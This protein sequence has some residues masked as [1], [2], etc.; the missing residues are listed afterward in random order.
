MNIPL[1]SLRSFIAVAE[2]GSMTAATQHIHISH[3]AV[4]QAIKTLEQQLGVTLFDRVGRQV[5]LNQV[6]KQYYHR[7]APALAEIDA[8]S[9]EAHNSQASSPPITLNMVNSLALHWWIPR[10]AKIQQALPELDIRLSTIVGK[11]DLAKHNVDV[12]LIHGNA[13]DWREYKCEQLADDE[14]VLVCSPLLLKDATAQTQNWQNLLTELPA[15]F[16]ANPRRESD[17]HIWCHANN[18]K[19]PPQ[20]KNLTF[21]T[22]VQATQAAIRQL[23]I[24]VSHRLFVKDDVNLGLLTEIGPVTINPTNQFNIISK[25]NINKSSEKLISWIKNE[26]VLNLN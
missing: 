1:K 9:Q 2:T 3:S 13:D 26:F 6:G 25:G 4:S 24:L 20:A 18:L 16:V 12:A 11:F 23:G 22:S 15:I 7:V 17:W 19:I 14:L 5:E 8:A 10:V 21:A